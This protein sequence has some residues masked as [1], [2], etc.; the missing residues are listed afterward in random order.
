MKHDKFM[1]RQYGRLKEKPKFVPLEAQAKKQA[2]DSMFGVD[3]GKIKRFTER[4][5]MEDRGADIR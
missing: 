4:D 1:E 5:R 3:K 2:P